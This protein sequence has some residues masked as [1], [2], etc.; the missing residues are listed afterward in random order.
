[1]LW[2][3]LLVPSSTKRRKKFKEILPLGAA[4]P[5][6]LL[7]VPPIPVPCGAGHKRGWQINV[8]A[9]SGREAVVLEPGVALGKGQ[10]WCEAHT[11]VCWQVLKAKF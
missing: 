3:N 11:Q 6:S 7:C 2:Y 5:G 1:M 10:P 9:E 8:G 4:V